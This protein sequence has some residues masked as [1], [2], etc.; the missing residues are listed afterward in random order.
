MQEYCILKIMFNGKTLNRMKKI[1]LLL[2]LLWLPF[3]LQADI[4][5]VQKL[6]GD[7]N[8]AQAL[9]SVER[10]L[11]TQPKHQQ[12]LFL[13]A[14]SLQQLGRDDDAIA[15]YKQLSINNPSLPEPYNNLAVLYAKQ[16]K[17][18]AA[19]TALL[20]AINTNSSYATAYKNLSD[21]Y[22]SM[23]ANAYN[24]ALAI[25]DKK[26]DPQL[27]LTTINKLEKKPV[28]T[29]VASIPLVKKV[30]VTQA[31]PV[32]KPND[33]SELIIDTI[34]GWSNAWSAQDS[35]AYLSY[36]STGFKPARGQSKKQWEKERRIRL[37]KPDFIRVSVQSPIV[38]MLS[39]KSA[40]LS[41]KQDYQSDRFNDAVQKTLLLEKVD[42]SWQI[43]KEFSS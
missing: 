38:K 28:I 34:Q 35:D 7:Q 14:F 9:D 1:P 24:K 17:Q 6:I 19:R 36:Y 3:A 8:Y 26:Q 10:L 29:T 30:P 33:E 20:S 39:S 25:K 37:K 43:L 41:F 42:G 23:A 18:A 16:G 32:S 12:A 21:I 2:G 4:N 27:A 40:L 11:D 31:K 5:Q 22:G 13:K 15:S